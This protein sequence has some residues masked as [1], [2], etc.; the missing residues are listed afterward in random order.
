VGGL[1]AGR[2]ALITGGAQGIGAACAERFVAEGASVLLADLQAEKGEAIAASLGATA[3]FVRLDVTDVQGWREAVSAAERRLGG[4][5]ILVNSAGV[6]V[7]AD[8]EHAD[9][10][11]WRRILATNLDSVFFGCREAMRLLKASR[12]GAIVNVASAL[13]LRPRPDFPAYSTTKSGLRGLSKSVAL[14]CAREGYAVRCNTVFPG[15]IDTPMAGA[16]R[17]AGTRE[18]QLAANA[19][20]HP[21]GRI[22]LPR[23]VAAGIAFLASD[24]ASFIT[25][26][27]LTIDGGLTI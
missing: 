25:G 16:N 19:A 20:R 22:G 8:V 7:A 5:D 11:H 26:A 23:E 12:A 17:K 21:M 13:G 18:D 4:L 1:L 3:A 14:H 10:E 27:E 15:S 9:D 24:E 6:S 2:R